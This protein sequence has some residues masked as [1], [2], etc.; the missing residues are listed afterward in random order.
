MPSPQSKAA[1]SN[2]P[3]NT[4]KTPSYLQTATTNNALSLDTIINTVLGTYECPATLLNPNKHVKAFCDVLADYSRRFPESHRVI[5]PHSSSETWRN[6]FNQYWSQFRSRNQWLDEPAT[7]ALLTKIADLSSAA[8]LIVQK[9]WM[10][11]V[12]LSDM[13]SYD[14]A[15]RIK[16]TGEMGDR[17][18]TH[19][20]LLHINFDGLAAVT[21][22]A[23]CNTGSNSDATDQTLINLATMNVNECRSLPQL[24]AMELD[25]WQACYRELDGPPMATYLRL[26]NLKAACDRDTVWCELNTAFNDI[27][28]RDKKI[29]IAKVKTWS[30][31]ES[32]FSEAWDLICNQ[33][34]LQR[35]DSLI[36]EDS[37]ID[38]YSSSSGSSSGLSTHHSFLPKKNNDGTFEDKATPQLE[39]QQLTCKDCKKDFK[40]SVDDQAHRARKGWHQNPVRC[41]P[42]KVIYLAKLA[43]DPQPCSDFKNG[44]C[45]F[46]D[47]CRY[48]HSSAPQKPSAEPGLTTHHIAFDEET[49]S[50]SDYDTDE[51][52][53]ECY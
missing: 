30:T 28:S 11:S 14:L 43:K 19:E 36:D 51:L 21:T 42:C 52:N 47:R 5:S 49:M 27:T 4:H 40:D 7:V 8:R 31:V 38:A 17:Q 18:A 22:E 32:K 6:E 34:F 3:A 50:P 10:H 29:K 12:G 39:D 9:A 37:S 2:A 41:P 24:L 16:A 46:G 26:N 25:L 1:A 53:P 44:S 20:D 15:A 35:F 23:L 45:S 48:S 33:G 13:E